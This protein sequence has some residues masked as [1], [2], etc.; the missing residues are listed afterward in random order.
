MSSHQPG[1]IDESVGN[2]EEWHRADPELTR[3]VELGHGVVAAFVVD[4]ISRS[5]WR[6]SRRIAPPIAWCEDRGT[7]YRVED[8][9][10]TISVD[11]VSGDSRGRRANHDAILRVV[12]DRGVDHGQATAL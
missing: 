12:R 1:V 7:G 8:A 4:T 6:G 10:R 3:V 9:V 5:N 11:V 2:C